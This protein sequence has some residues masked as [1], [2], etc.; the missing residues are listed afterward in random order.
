[1]TTG[2]S[3]SRKYRVWDM[4]EFANVN[5]SMDAAVPRKLAQPYFVGR[6]SCGLIY[7]VISW[8]TGVISWVTEV[9]TH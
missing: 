3:W 8:V 9:I 7:G 5:L 2:Q 4:K 1:M 6:V